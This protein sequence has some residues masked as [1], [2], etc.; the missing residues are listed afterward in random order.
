MPGLKTNPVPRDT[1]E[2]ELV[3]GKETHV[4]AP[5]TMEGLTPA[6][7]QSFTFLRKGGRWNALR[8]FFALLDIFILLCLLF[9]YSDA[10]C[11]F[12]IVI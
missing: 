9:F 12:V 7:S 1:E 5:R 6:G 4:V 3:P 10:H 8:E 11:I 2:P